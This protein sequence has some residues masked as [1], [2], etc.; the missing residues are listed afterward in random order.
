MTTFS[1]RARSGWRWSTAGKSRGLR[2]RQC[3][4]VTNAKLI[5]SCEGLIVRRVKSVLDA[6]SYI[7]VRTSLNPGVGNPG[8]YQSFGAVTY[9]E[10][11]PS[12]YLQAAMGSLSAVQVASGCFQITM[13]PY[14]VLNRLRSQSG[15]KVVAA[16]SIGNA[17]NGHWQIWTLSNF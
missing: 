3:A 16:N 8:A 4:V 17:Q 13:S 6:M 9:V 14:A 5:Q 2:T 12:P 11:E 7:T 15:F 1:V 10:C